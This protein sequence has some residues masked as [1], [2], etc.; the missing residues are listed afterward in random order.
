MEADA[1]LVRRTLRGETDAFRELL[2][3]YTGA[4]F[5]LIYSCVGR[6]EHVEDVAQEVFLQTY[7]SLRNLKDPSRFGSWLYGLTKRI[8]MNWLRRQ[9]TAQLSLDEVREP[10][11]RG[12]SPDPARAASDDERE[13]LEILQS[14]PLIYREVVHLRYIE[15]YSY[16]EIARILDVSE[17]A[18][19]IRLIKARR[20]LR[21]RIERSRSRGEP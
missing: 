2:N 21:E 1:A 6:N 20:M 19:N 12:P 9:K 17:S 4:V 3:R 5:A 7:R 14:L 11:I 10:P 15:D 13:V 18:V 16:R 8:C